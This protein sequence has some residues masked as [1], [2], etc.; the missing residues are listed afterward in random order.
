MKL[1]KNSISILLSLLLFTFLSLPV[2]PVFAAES[3]ENSITIN[4]YELVK[5]LA[6]ESISSLQE[7]NFDSAEISDI[8]NYKNVFNL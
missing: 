5:Q 3:N 7:K 6:G 8:K 1:F 2:I 4:E